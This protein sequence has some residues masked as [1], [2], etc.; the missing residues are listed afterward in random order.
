M[1]FQVNGS[2]GKYD[3][4]VADESVKYGRNAVENHLQYME[5]P[6]VNDKDVP[7]P[8][9]NFS[10]TVNA[11]EEN[12]QKLEKFVKANDEYLSKLPP[13]EYEYRYMAKPV[14]GN[15]DK[16]SLYGNAYE[17]MQAKE[18]SV[19]EFEN[20]YLINNDYTAE[21]LDINKDGKIDVAEY[22][23]N[24]LAA[25]ILSKGTTDVRAVDGTINEKGWNAILAY[26]KKANAAAATKLYSNIYNTYNL[27][28]NVS[29]FK[30]E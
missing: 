17:E 10:P 29:E 7:A 9:L 2:N 24:I 3:K 11:G 26:T 12:I 8:I 13:L 23:A 19:K 16:K 30:P 4:L 14:N 28:S 22:G 21:P 6:L 18:L 15:I 20:R 27:S 1:T 25:D 5:A